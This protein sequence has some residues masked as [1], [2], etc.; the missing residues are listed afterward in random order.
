[1]QNDELTKVAEQFVDAVRNGMEEKNRIAS[2]R[3]LEAIEVEEVE[4][5]HVQILVPRHFKF[6][7]RGAAPTKR[8]ARP[9]KERYK[10][11]HEW[12]KNKGIVSDDSTKSKK[13][14]GAI[15]TKIKNEGTRAY[16][17]GGEDVFSSKIDELSKNYA[18]LLIN[19][20]LH[21]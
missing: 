20:Y 16:K 15:A 2:G 6:I 18:N 3:T 8:G 17:M 7:E 14:T 13:I 5:N 10:V 11:I 19:N 9:W 21:L 12:A 4:D 1:M